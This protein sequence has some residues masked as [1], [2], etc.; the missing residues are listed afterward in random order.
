MPWGLNRPMSG[1]NSIVSTVGP[2]SPSTGAGMRS[3]VWSERFPR[4]ASRESCSAVKSSWR[5]TAPPSCPIISSAGRSR[6]L[7]S[8]RPARAPSRASRRSAS[9]TGRMPCRCTLTATSVPSASRARCTLAIVPQATGSQSNSAKASEN[10]ASA[11]VRATAARLGCRT[12]SAS[13]PNASHQRSGTRSRRVLSSCP[14]LTKNGPSAVSSRGAR[15]ASLARP[16]RVIV[17]GSAAIRCPVTIRAVAQARFGSS[18]Q[19]VRCSRTATPDPSC[20]AD[21]RR[22][23]S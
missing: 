8:S 18:H 20:R 12:S 17:C 6:M 10:P 7:G 2:H 11:R 1:T 5:R 13:S 16:P 15:C 4:S 14:A 3:S 22:P 19:L 21:R 23:A 9:S